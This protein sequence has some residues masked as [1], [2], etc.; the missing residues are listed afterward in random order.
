MI[1]LFTPPF[2][3]SKLEPGYIK[4]YVPG[5]RENGGQYT[6]AATWVI[7]AYS[8]MKNTNKAFRTFNMINP[9]TH[10]KTYG[11]CNTYKTEPYVVVADIYSTEGHVGRGG[12]SWY[13]GSAGW[14]YRGA[15]EGI[16]GLKLK[17]KDGFIVEPCIPDDW[18]GYTMKFSRN[19]ATYNIVIE[20]GNNKGIYVNE[21]KVDIV[22]YDL[23][24][25]I[26]VKVII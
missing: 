20:R 4:G 26:E 2:N 13:T 10:T 21:N 18:N 3:N 25:E 23:Y 17:G 15:I 12:W 22:S 14:L 8:K 9:I 11:D 24:G 19:N 16:L 5:V 6:H 7:L 1:L